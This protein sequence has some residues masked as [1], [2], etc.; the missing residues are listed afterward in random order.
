M[1]QNGWFYRQNRLT[2]KGSF[3]TLVVSSLLG[4]AIRVES[5]RSIN[6]KN[7]TNNRDAEQ[8]STGSNYRVLAVGLPLILPCL[9]GILCI[10]VRT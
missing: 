4:R 7:N 3:D 2:R 9:L 10:G 6:M 5:G 8:V 1:N